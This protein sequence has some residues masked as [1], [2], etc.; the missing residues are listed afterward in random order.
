MEQQPQGDG[1][2]DT[3]GWSCPYTWWTSGSVAL[4]AAGVGRR[5]AL[6]EA[7]CGLGAAVA[8][9]GAVEEQVADRAVDQA[10]AR[11]GGLRVL[12]AAAGAT[13]TRRGGPGRSAEPLERV[14]GEVRRSARS[15]RASTGS[16]RGS[17]KAARLCSSDQRAVVSDS[18]SFA[19][20]TGGGNP[21][22]HVSY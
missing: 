11:G 2:P 4:G 12:D 1:H 13:T 8:A 20:V 14:S 10:A 16:R 3:T 19:T 15:H 18:L 17:S 7:D 5:R 9:E 21:D 6:D 22:R